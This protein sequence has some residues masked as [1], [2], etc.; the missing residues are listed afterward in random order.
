MAAPPPMI[1]KF[2]GAAVGIEFAHHKIHAEDFYTAHYESDP[3]ALPTNAGEETAISFSTPTEQISALRI[4]MFFD[5][6]A[7]DESVL[8][9]RE[10]PAVALNQQS[11]LPIFNR[12][13]SSANTSI[14]RGSDLGQT[15]GQLSSHTVIEAAA[16]GLAGGT[17]LH[18]ETIAIGANPPFRSVLNG[19]ARAE[20]EWVLLP[21]TVYVLILTSSTI[22]DTVHNLIL[23]W[24]EH[25]DSQYGH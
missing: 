8:E 24:Y 19:Q 6:W 25:A 4:H 16:A 17:I 9:F 10:G 18:H 5:A 13:R 1:D 2:S 12:K 14:L 7:N 20:R 23:N 11:I 21:G 22:N 3:A 15:A